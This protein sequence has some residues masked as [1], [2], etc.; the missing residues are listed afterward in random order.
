MWEVATHTHHTL[1]TTTLPHTLQRYRYQYHLYL[2]TV[3]RYCDIVPAI[4]NITGKGEGMSRK[5]SRAKRTAVWLESRASRQYSK[6][7]NRRLLLDFELA[8]LDIQPHG[9]IVQV[10]YKHKQQ[11]AEWNRLRA[12]RA[13]FADTGLLPHQPMPNSRLDLWPKT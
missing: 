7:Q 2:L 3:K 9:S 8:R 4:D 6:A 12:Q 13:N 1:A 11:A 5:E 10:R